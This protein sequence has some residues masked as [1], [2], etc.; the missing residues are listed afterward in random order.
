MLVD[1]TQIET[2]TRILNSILLLKDI[3]D[4]YNISNSNTANPAQVQ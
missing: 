3:N 1:R 2:T 4:I